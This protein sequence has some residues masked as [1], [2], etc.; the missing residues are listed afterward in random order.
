L[1]HFEAVL[2]AFREFSKLLADEDVDPEL[3]EPL[4]RMGWNTKTVHDAGVF[5]RSDEAVWGAARTEDRVLLT[6][7]RGF[8][9]ERRFPIGQGPGLVVLPAASPNADGLLTALPRALSIMGRHRE[10]WRATKAIAGAE[11][12]LTIRCVDFHSA[13][14]ETARF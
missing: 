11:G 12:T 2:R 9:D 10:I 6:T 14:I 7:D 13:K 8:L 5:G 4:R 1:R 3:V